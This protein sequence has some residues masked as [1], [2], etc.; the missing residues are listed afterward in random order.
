[1]NKMIRKTKKEK[2]VRKAKTY[3]VIHA[4]F[5]GH[6][7]NVGDDCPKSIHRF[8][9]MD[10]IWLDAGICN[11]CTLKPCSY[12]KAWKEWLNGNKNRNIEGISE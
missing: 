12:F 8:K 3:K 11:G 7:P 10:T 5:G 2:M 4:N 9:H 1:M 6:V